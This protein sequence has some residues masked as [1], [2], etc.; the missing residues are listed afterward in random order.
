MCLS[1]ARA[2]F[3]R[4]SQAL[5]TQCRADAMMSEAVPLTVQVPGGVGDL[6][7]TDEAGAASPVVSPGPETLRAQV[8]RQ[9]P[10]IQASTA[11]QDAK[12]QHVLFNKDGLRELQNPMREFKDQYVVNLWKVYNH[13]Y[14]GHRSAG[15]IRNLL[16]YAVYVYVITL[17]LWHLPP[18]GVMLR[19]QEAVS[20]L[21]LGEEFD[22]ETTHI[23]KNFDDVMTAEEMW[24]WAE[25]PL[26][27]GLLVDGEPDGK[28][29]ALLGTNW[30]MGPVRL[31][32]ERSR[33]EPRKC[34]DKL[35]RSFGPDMGEQLTDRGVRCT[36]D[37]NDH[38][39]TDFLNLSQPLEA[40]DGRSFID[41]F[42]EWYR[43]HAM[44]NKTS[45]G[46]FCCS[47]SACF[48]TPED[49]KQ[50]IN[51]D[52]DTPKFEWACS[53]NLQ[54]HTLH[55]NPTRAYRSD[56]KSDPTQTANLW[57]KFRSFGTGGFHI[58]LPGDSSTF[59]RQLKALRELQFVDQYT[60]SLTFQ[61][62]IL[63][64]N[65]FS[66]S[67][68]SPFVDILGSD[69]DPTVIVAVDV[70]FVFSPSGHVKSYSRITSMQLRPLHFL[71][72]GLSE[73]EE[74]GSSGWIW[75]YAIVVLPFWMM[76]QEFQKLNTVGFWVWIRVGW[77]VF[78]FI[79][80][81]AMYVL[82]AEIRKFSQ[83]EERFLLQYKFNAT[84]EDYDLG[85]FSSDIP[86]YVDLT[87]NTQG[88][89]NDVL[90]LRS[91]YTAMVKFLGIVCLV[92]V[93]KIFKYM[94]VFKSTSLLWDTLRLAAGQ[95]LA[96]TAV[97]FWVIF[98]F[99]LCTT[100][101][102][103]RHT[104]GF[105]NIP[106]SMFQLVRLAA[107]VDEITYSELKHGDA[108]MTPAI[109][110]LFIGLVAIL[111]MNLMIAIV[112]DFYE[113]ARDTLRAYEQDFSWIQHAFSSNS[114]YEDFYRGKG[115]WNEPVTES[116]TGAVGEV[117]QALRGT[118]KVKPVPI[119][120]GPR[121]WD[122][123]Q[124]EVRALGESQSYP[125]VLHRS[126]RVQLRYR[127]ESHEHGAIA[128][129]EPQTTGPAPR[130]SS[131]EH[132]FSSRSR[133]HGHSQAEASEESPRVTAL[134]TMKLSMATIVSTTSS[135]LKTIEQLA[136]SV[137]KQT[138]RMAFAADLDQHIDANSPQ[139]DIPRQ[140]EAPTL[141]LWMAASS[142]AQ[143]RGIRYL[144]TLQSSS[145]H[146]DPK[147]Q[148]LR[149]AKP[150]DRVKLRTP[151][152]GGLTG[153]IT[154]EFVGFKPM[155]RASR[156]DKQ[157]MCRAIEHVREELNDLQVEFEA[158]RQQ[159][160]DS[161]VD[162]HV[163]RLRGRNN[164]AVSIGPIDPE[165]VPLCPGCFSSN[166]ELCQNKQHYAERIAGV[167]SRLQ[168]LHMQRGELEGVERSM[169]F[170]VVDVNS[171]Q[172][173]RPMTVNMGALGERLKEA[174]LECV[175][176]TVSGSPD[177]AVENSFKDNPNMHLISKTAVIDVVAGAVLAGVERQMAGLTE[178][179]QAA[180]KNTI[181]MAIDG[182][183]TEMANEEAEIK[184]CNTEA[185][186][187]I[188]E[189][190]EKRRF[191]CFST[192]CGSHFHITQ[193][194]K[195]HETMMLLRDHGEIALDLL[196]PN[197]HVAHPSVSEAMNRLV[198]KAQRIEL[199]R[200]HTPLLEVMESAE[201][202]LQIPGEVQRSIVFRSLCRVP[203]VGQIKRVLQWAFPVHFITKHFYFHSAVEDDVDDFLEAKCIE[204]EARMS[205]A[206]KRSLK[207]AMREC[208]S[209][210]HSINLSDFIY[211][212]QYFV[213][214]VK[215]RGI[216]PRVRAWCHRTLKDTWLR[217]CVLGLRIRMREH[218][219]QVEAEIAMNYLLTH[220][221]DFIDRRR[222]SIP[223]D[224][225]DAGGVL[226]EQN[227]R[228]ALD[229]VFL[230]AQ[231]A[232]GEQDHPDDKKRTR[233]K[234]LELEPE[235]EP[236]PEP[237]LQP[238]PNDDSEIN[239]DAKQLQAKL[240]EVGAL[241][242]SIHRQ[243]QQKQQLHAGAGTMQLQAEL[244]EE[245]VQY[246]SGAQKSRTPPGRP[247]NDS[248]TIPLQAVQNPSQQGRDRP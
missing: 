53:V 61:F 223:G 35:S 120:C 28:L 66:V 235:P 200:P 63:N 132:L 113:E 13:H 90:P 48:R 86:S 106:S 143:F 58:D 165:G 24:Q 189:Q 93:F 145:N 52:A 217:H 134:N 178:K 20:D 5:R 137:S 234:V 192:R 128:S 239:F 97:M 103:G 25:G 164:A 179:E 12:A 175:L 182:I 242:E 219:S 222:G 42:P 84:R 7:D 96:Y 168:R 139:A 247:P 78:E 155:R 82:C 112:T 60:R 50:A 133:V 232:D 71:G 127:V 23:F 117:L 125:F 99:S 151:A 243:Q 115:L 229:K 159:I 45:E 18:P 10:L 195:T 184:Q 140:Y 30:L 114:K 218:Y 171:W 231:E 209:A 3:L 47:Q 169:L 19:H 135:A 56:I 246:D 9:L 119:G 11:F 74:V 211:Q 158:R 101:I 123:E 161:V 108:T 2:A 29:A 124:K 194:M 181:K 43:V 49:Q 57:A 240:A 245:G 157:K 146:P 225:Y 244:A 202:E 144:E 248:R 198:K 98:A 69:F 102:W 83:E 205:R 173:F 210:E 76:L 26:S 46:F 104:I 172:K 40:L 4:P 64:G 188:N 221:N 197:Y 44:A 87:I 228:A 92:S 107:G 38:N 190:A 27:A 213:F 215:S 176:R 1:A 33:E 142:L 162:E 167:E 236:E 183:I 121:K 207:L 122:A 31:R 180:H 230:D 79:Y 65:T 186:Q 8:H 130:T 220:Y 238:E 166:C 185:E 85:S 233:N 68:D 95:L 152:E 14:L 67:Q 6:D 204:A 203:S 110:L 241:L 116:A 36:S 170:D 16:F 147:D 41:A 80:I 201:F 208:M 206:V 81:G 34:Q 226:L 73:A 55:A 21:L 160:I 163:Q 91:T 100:L 136:H 131:V 105:Q 72:I 126:S 148:E 224:P 237:Q 191:K 39:A 32:Q 214:K 75:G 193:A 62:I 22:E 150:G 187:K 88:M 196:V 177:R 77:N 153:E 138:T 156:R 111:G 118:W 17:L 54:N 51:G 59:V 89:F 15:Q 149:N 109:F 94:R 154:L 199:C 174:C 70:N 129:T 227:T 37:W 212:L 216:V 141:D